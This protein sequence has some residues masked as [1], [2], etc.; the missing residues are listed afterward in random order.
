MSQVI[1]VMF[2]SHNPDLSSFMTLL[3]DCKHGQH[4]N[5]CHKWRRNHFL[6]R[7]SFQL[8]FSCSFCSITCFHV[9]SFVLWCPLRFPRKNDVQLVSRLFCREF[10]FYLCY[11]YLFTWC[12]KRFPYKIVVLSFNSNT[13]GATSG[14]GNSF[15]SEVFS[16]LW[17]AQTLVFC[18]VFHLPLFCLSSYFLSL[19][20]LSFFDYGSDYPFDIYKLFLINT[21]NNYLNIYYF[22]V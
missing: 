6:I 18:V 19:Y 7:H 12:P 4:N 3:L 17:V 5:G 15:I 1:T 11:L 22:F 2:R 21:C 13:T 16:W 14:A 20:C 8:G 9:F 10:K